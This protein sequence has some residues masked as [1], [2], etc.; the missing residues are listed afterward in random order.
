MA[1]PDFFPTL[2]P[3]EQL[4]GLGS[5]AAFLIVS[6][7]L[8]S[9]GHFP[10]TA[11]PL[12][13]AAVAGVI[14]LPFITGSLLLGTAIIALFLAESAMP[15]VKIDLLGEESR[16]NA[17][18][19]FVNGAME[20]LAFTIVYV[21]LYVPY[22]QTWG[23]R[24]H[25]VPVW[26]QGIGVLLL[27]DFMRY[28][29]H[30]FQHQYDWWWKFHEIH[31]SSRQINWLAGGRAHIFEALI[32][33][34]GHNVVIYLLDVDLSA[35]LFGFALPYTVVAFI[36]AHANLD[37]PRAGQ[38]LPFWSYIITSPTTHAAHHRSDTDKTLYFGAILTI[39][40]VI[41][42][43]FA[44]SVPKNVTYGTDP[45]FPD[46]YLEQQMEPFR[47]LIGSKRPI[48]QEDGEAG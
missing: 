38:P 22:P 48:E 8:H 20:P 3:R 33:G 9:R 13:A 47:K 44:P 28:W 17:V 31:H 14:L 39:W 12:A 19:T 32:L 15:R 46:A 1:F 26:I 37:F 40:D 4:A 23:L 27:L 45:D 43:T 16:L 42:G 21:T 7:K 35:L 6:E 41:F 10:R 25:H 30:R 29:R 2:T 11:R 18:Y 5:L 34:L 24:S 36:F